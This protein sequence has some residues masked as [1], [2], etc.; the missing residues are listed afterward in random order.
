M[1]NP[2]QYTV[3]LVLSHEG[4]ARMGAHIDRSFSPKNADPDRL[5][6]NQELLFDLRDEVEVT[7]NLEGDVWRRINAC[8][9]EKMR[10]RRDSRLAV[11]VK[12]SGSHERM[13]E[14][15]SNPDLFV[16]W[17][18]AN[19]DFACREFGKKNIVPK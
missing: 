16:S 17:K 5:H 11:G 15:A 7:S 6:L 9:T 4:L 18:Q 2:P 10:I 19:Y 12:L 8:K 13:K 3:F 1:S 14:I